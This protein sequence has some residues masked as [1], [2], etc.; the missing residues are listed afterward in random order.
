MC[1]RRCRTIAVARGQRLLQEGE[2]RH[3]EAIQRVSA[4][5][6]NADHAE[7]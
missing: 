6:G 2:G 1:L 5:S 3:A 4:P 7:E